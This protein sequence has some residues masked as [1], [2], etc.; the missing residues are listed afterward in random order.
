[1]IQHTRA[2]LAVLLL[3][4]FAAAQEKS[5]EE[6]KAA[7]D[8]VG[9]V[10]SF[11]DEETV[12]VA[13]V[14]A[15]KLDLSGAARQVKRLLGDIVGDELTMAALAGEVALG[16]VTAAGAREGYL[17]VSLADVP[18]RPPFGILPVAKGTSPAALARALRPLVTSAGPPGTVVTPSGALAQSLAIVC[19]PVE[20]AVFIGPGASLERLK[21]RL[22]EKADAD[23]RAAAAL[24]NKDLAQA[25]AAAG[26]GAVQ[27]ALL[28]SADQRRVIDELFPNLPRAVGG[29]STRPFSEGLRFAALGV[30]VSAKV[31]LRF[32]MQAKDEASAQAQGAVIT[33]GWELFAS[34]AEIKKHLPA[35]DRIAKALSPRVIGNQIV[36][37]LSEENEGLSNLMRGLIPAL[38][39]A[40]MTA[41]RQITANRL[42]Q[43][44][45]ALHNYHD[46][47]GA[48][49]ARANF[50]TASKP[51][52]SWRVHMLPY[53]EGDHLYKQFR[54]DEPWDSE[55]N[56]KL[57]DK[58]PEVFQAQ[59]SKHKTDSGLTTFLAPVSKG[60]V[61]AV[62]K[63]TK[64]ADI[65]DG[66]SN[67][68]AVVQVSDEAAVPWTKPDDWQ[69]N[70]KD[71]LKGLADDFAAL[72]CDGSVRFFKKDTKPETLR[73]MIT[74]DGGEIVPQ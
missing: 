14:D 24:R 61:L 73:A 50:G 38:T 47:H 53:V 22:S 1:M 49:P 40:R 34:S 21:Q 9:S 10:A 8:S 26:D 3:A 5:G 31:S 42:K 43:L 57:V 41:S 27:A 45:I 37:E 60:S 4:G 25:L 56:K 46:T 68:I 20:G 62:D 69:V 74:R 44:G 15:S 71:P 59:G 70:A 51:L 33:K 17:I 35:A 32:V 6:K 63:G 39:G 67:T 52:L 7:S 54:L 18:F 12:F 72:F 66:T 28:L 11:L 19:E 55:H 36:L 23:A 16:G 58:M 64:I 30:N 65:F 29:G 13:R 48:F 2:I